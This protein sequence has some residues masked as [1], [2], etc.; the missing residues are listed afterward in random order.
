ML[1]KQDGA[2]SSAAAPRALYNTS[3]YEAPRLRAQRRVLVM[4]CFK[5]LLFLKP[6]ARV[7]MIVEL[8]LY[9]AAGFPV[10]VKLRFSLIIRRS[11]FQ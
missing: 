4:G 10:S 6:Y 11:N 3:G 8:L 9:V 2:D 5:K 7:L 1:W